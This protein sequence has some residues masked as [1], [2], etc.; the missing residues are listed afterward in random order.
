MN[1]KFSNFVGIL[2]FIWTDINDLTPNSTLHHKFKV[3]FDI[4][5]QSHLYS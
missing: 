3:Y 1:S 5:G 2:G 4:R